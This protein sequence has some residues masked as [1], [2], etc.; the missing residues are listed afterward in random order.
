MEQ[1]QRT[2]GFRFS[3]VDG[4]V[5]AATAVI[6]PPLVSIV[7]TTGWLPAVVVGH[8]FLFCNVFRIR[9]K[10]EL[11][12]AGCFVAIAAAVSVTSLET[13][14]MMILPLPLTVL[15]IAHEFRHPSYHGILSS[16][17]NPEAVAARAAG[18]RSV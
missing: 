1:K 4:I 12:W 5:L 14:W 7:E 11:I 15:L 18:N 8:F 6:T 3:F 17:V 10:P 2:F 9:R 16:R 13:I